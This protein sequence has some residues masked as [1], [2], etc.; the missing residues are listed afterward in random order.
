[1]LLACLSPVCFGIPRERRLRIVD[2]GTTESRE[3]SLDVAL[4]QSRCKRF[5]AA[6]NGTQE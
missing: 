1:M 2:R 5:H 4:D 6:V 3:V